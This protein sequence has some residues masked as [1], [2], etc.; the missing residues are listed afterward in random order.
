MRALRLPAFA[1]DARDVALVDHDPGPPGPGEVR[2]RMRYAPVH[3]SDL[4]WVRGTYHAALER[5][6]WNHGR[7]GAS[8]D[9]A[10]EK[11]AK[12]PPYVLGVEGMGVVTE[13]GPGFL[14]N[15]LVG[16]RV[17]VASGRE[18]TFQEETVVL[19]KQ[20]VPLPASI[21]DA[22]GAMFFVNPLT[23]WVLVH[24]VLRAK[25]GGTLL[26]TAAG[27]ALGRMVLGLCRE[28]G[29]EAIAVVRKPGAEDAL[30]AAGAAHVVATD[31]E[32]LPSAVARI[33]GGR[34]VHYATDCVGGALA[35]EVIRCMAPSGH[36]VLYGTLSNTH[37]SLPP[38]DLMMPRVRVE[39]FFLGA[40]L[41]EA[42]LA[43][44]LGCIRAVKKRIAS[45]ML[46]S[47]VGSISP[48]EAHAEVFARA[49]K[50]GG[51]KHL[52]SFDA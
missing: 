21:E 25:A 5:L 34:G 36:V 43:T 32:D 28:A 33:T 49:A 7:E 48:L 2:V 16:K 27:S 29:I 6:I 47:E 15:R 17:A 4:N 44:K 41:A 38:R 12:T 8:F 13:A 37:I 52:F 9:V 11:P 19:A 24:R 51:P 22:Q 31:V 3:P 1:D 50:G 10:G 26:H 42:S 30:R 35:G 14:G 23:A 45:G 40:Y 46:A 39:G 20:A 18:G